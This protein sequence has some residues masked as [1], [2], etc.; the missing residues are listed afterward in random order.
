M[1]VSDETD[2]TLFVGNLDPN[3]TEELLFEL[4]LQ[5]GPLYKVKIPKD[6]DGKQKGFGFV[7]FKHEFRAGSSHINNPVN[8][9][10]QSPVNTPSPHGSGGRYEKSRDQMGSPSFSPPQHIQR[11]FSSPDSLQRRVL[12]NNIWQLQIQ[13]Q[14]LQSM[15]GGIPAYGNG[16]LGQPPQS[17][18]AGGPCQQESSSQRGNSH[19]GREMHSGG[20][21]DTGS[22]RHH[23]SQRDDQYRHDSRS[24]SS[25]SREDRCRDGSRDNR[26]RRY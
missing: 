24:G 2:R 6:N 4:F 11:S 10:N 13:Q 19:Y 15:H 23:R 20:S 17:Q 3:V 22:S 12:M 1:G 5:A 14:Q 16:L 9:Q 8:S 18:R 7:C 25:H 26:W 21:D